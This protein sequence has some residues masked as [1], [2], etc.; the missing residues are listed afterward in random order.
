[1]EQLGYL[2]WLADQAIGGLLYIWPVSVIFL[3]FLV[4]SLVYTF[5]TGAW[6]S[7]KEVVLVLVPL[8]GPIA[9]LTS[10][11]VLKE[12]GVSYSLVPAALFAVNGV[13]CLY[14]IWRSPT[15]RVVTVAASLF[16]IWYSFWCWFVAGMSIGGDW[17]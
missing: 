10:G 14:S 1:M 17:L 3:A 13:L 6:S 15:V 5:C 4:A 12:R 9:I 2:L 7:S 8:L 16:V 11:V